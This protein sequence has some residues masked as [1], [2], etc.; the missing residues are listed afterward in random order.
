MVLCFNCFV[1]SLI[2]HELVC[3]Q[4]FFCLRLAFLSNKPKTRAQACLIYKQTN[5]KEL[6]IESNLICS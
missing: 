6:F 5:I 2:A 4:I 3:E 1:L